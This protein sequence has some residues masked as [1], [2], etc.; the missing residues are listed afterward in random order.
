MFVD[1]HFPTALE[2]NM[3]VSRVPG[4]RPPA[5]AT[6]VRFAS[7]ASPA[8]VSEI[9]GPGASPKKPAGATQDVM[10]QVSERRSPS[11][12]QGQEQVLQSEGSAGLGRVAGGKKE[13]MLLGRLKK[14]FQSQLRALAQSDPDKLQGILKQAF[15]KKI[16][17][18]AMDRIIEQSLG[19]FPLPANVKLVDGD[20]LKGAN[21]AY[22]PSDGGTIFINRELIGDPQALKAVF[23]EEMGHHID[24]QLGGADS[25]GDEGELFQ[26]ALAKGGPLSSGEA[27]S[28][29]KQRDTGTIT[30][31]GQQLT[32]E[33]QKLDQVTDAVLD[34]FEKNQRAAKKGRT[35]RTSSRLSRNLKNVGRSL[36]KA[37][38]HGDKKQLGQIREMLS[39]IKGELFDVR[40][41]SG[42]PPR[43][44]KVNEHKAKMAAKILNGFSEGGRGKAEGFIDNVLKPLFGN[45][46][47][48]LLGALRDMQ[49]FGAAK[50]DLAVLHAPL[51]ARR[52]QEI[53]K[54]REKILKKMT[55]NLPGWE[56]VASGGSQHDR[57]MTS[58]ILRNS[59]QDLR[60]NFGKVGAN[61]NVQFSDSRVE[62]LYNRIKASTEKIE[63]SEFGR[64]GEDIVS[65]FRRK[66][67]DQFDA[68]DQMSTLLRKM[69]LTFDT[70]KA[71]HPPKFDSPEA[72]QVYTSLY[73][74]LVGATQ[75]ISEGIDL[76]T[77]GLKHLNKAEGIDPKKV[78]VRNDRGNQGPLMA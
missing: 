61:G 31:D 56:R 47:G 30:V 3:S 37:L 22:S 77:L 45:E 7:S 51:K 59:L 10:T 36:S 26:K 53:G 12:D 23:N 75:A 1:E 73:V 28:I 32:V 27:A 69:R 8:Q 33:F 42:F 67:V 21:G 41:D 74:Q 17:A 2:S 6:S 63:L 78:L 25:L 19:E 65:Q 15:G 70:S 4:G 40:R 76:S 14:G 29:R 57:E 9:P 44:L 64:M 62:G 52:Q 11:T 39:D 68:G 71:T 43:G 49:G 20:A 50:D 5:T 34:D 16:D 13:T 46:T 60:R 35:S 55:Q 48:F 18:G 24:Q 58:I 72:Q 54:N 38:K 66:N